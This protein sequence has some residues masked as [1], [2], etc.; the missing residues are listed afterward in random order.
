MPSTIQII[1]LVVGF[2]FLIHVLLLTAKNKLY[3]KYAFLW[4]LFGV[5]G[6]VVAFS[7]T[8]LN[9]MAAILGIA[10][11]PSLIFMLAF[12]VVLFVLTYQTTLISNHE[13]V[14]KVLIQEIAFLD[15]RIKESEEENS[16]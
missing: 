6:V 8:Y 10:Y 4:I 13:K 15:K 7:L 9:D 3:D 5:T 1:V 12:L 14:I 16:K 2:L 11:M